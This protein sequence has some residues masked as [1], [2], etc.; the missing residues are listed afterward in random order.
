MWDPDLLRE[1]KAQTK[2]LAVKINVGR[3]CWQLTPSMRILIKQSTTN[4]DPAV[5][6]GV[7]KHDSFKSF[8]DMSAFLV[9][10][11]DQYMRLGHYCGIKSFVCISQ[12]GVQH[13]QK[14]FFFN[15]ARPSW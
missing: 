15:V 5:Q 10:V 7:V 1:Q 12:F 8:N 11:A 3:H 4:G 13:I 2:N 6:P 9:S 14:L